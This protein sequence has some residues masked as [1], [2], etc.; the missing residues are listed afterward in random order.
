MPATM[1]LAHTR[2]VHPP[3]TRTHTA[4]TITHQVPSDLHVEVIDDAGHYVFLEQ[5]QLFNAALL[6]ACA[7]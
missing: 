2:T 7:P 6:D 1:C 5:P 3:H 4:S